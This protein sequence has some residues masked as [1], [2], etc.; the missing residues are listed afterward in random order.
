M[1]LLTP[2]AETLEQAAE[3]LAKGKL[4]AFPTETVY[5][6]G[7]DATSDSAISALYAAKARPVVNPLIVHLGDKA[8]AERLCVLDT[9]AQRLAEAFWPGPLTLVAPLSDL[10]VASIASAVTA[11][12]PTLAVR[13]PAHPIAHALLKAVNRPIAAPSANRSGR[14][15]ATEAQHIADDFAESE[16]RPSIILDAG[17]TEHGLE[18]SI[19]LCDPA[20]G[21]ATLLRHGAISRA[22]LEATLG[23]PLQALEGDESRPLSPGRSFRHYAPA[24][25]LRLLRQGESPQ[26]EDT[27]AW[28]GFGKLEPI[29]S[30]IASE[31]L[32]PSGNAL[33]AAHRLF[34]AL[35]RLEGSG[36][37]SIVVAPIPASAEALCERL[38][39][40]GSKYP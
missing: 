37:T 40:A 15:S 3:E 10:S 16:F 8:Q 14:P 26:V 23:A 30:P 1:K 4:V 9:Q 35:R 12:L 28:L 36:A 27:E 6:L 38:A 18:S 7:A 20:T 13:V 5:G 33:E 34:A 31:S 21:G 17:A 29:G 39:R 22:D 2:T 11:G 25:P 32:S 24:I 19:V